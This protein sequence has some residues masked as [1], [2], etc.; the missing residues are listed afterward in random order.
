MPG[1]PSACS[2]FENATDPIPVRCEHHFTLSSSALAE[3]NRHKRRDAD[4]A[5]LNE[6]KHRDKT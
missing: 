3:P 4:T 1:K 5:S 2:E 6:P